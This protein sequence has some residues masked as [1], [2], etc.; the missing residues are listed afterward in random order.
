[1][2]FF[3]ILFVYTGV[4]WESLGVVDLLRFSGYPKWMI[5]DAM[6]TDWYPY[7]FA[8]SLYQIYRRNHELDVLY[9]LKFII[10]LYF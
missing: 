2:A 8:S 9:F 7:P 4:V 1:M 6:D 10:L 5:S 3:L